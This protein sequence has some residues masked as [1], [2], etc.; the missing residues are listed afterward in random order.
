MPIHPF[1][2]LPALFAV[3]SIGALAFLLRWERRHFLRLGKGHAWLAVRLATIPIALA[4]AALILI[5]ARATPGMEGLAVLYI[6]LFTLAPVFWFGAHWIAG[7][8][9]RPPLSFA[10]SAQVAASPV[11]LG[12]VLSALAHALQPIAGSMLRAMGKG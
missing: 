7:K 6:L 1:H 2:I 8:F 3:L 9:V 12:V 11:V 5:P 4:T 10:E